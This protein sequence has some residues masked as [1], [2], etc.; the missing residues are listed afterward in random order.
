M[1]DS[2]LTFEDYNYLSFSSISDNGKSVCYKA[3]NGTK[4]TYSMSVKL[5]GVTTLST[6]ISAE[7]FFDGTAYKSW[8]GSPKIKATD[9]TYPV[10]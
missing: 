8:P 1:C 10:L 5:V 4:T 3:V 6:N 7:S 9:Y 2:T